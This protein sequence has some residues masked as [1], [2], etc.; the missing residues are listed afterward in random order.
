MQCCF[1]VCVCFNR[2]ILFVPSCGQNEQE[3]KCVVQY[4]HVFDELL[5]QFRGGDVYDVCESVLSETPEL[6][7]QNIKPVDPCI[8]VAQS[9]RDRNENR[10]AFANSET[11]VFLPF[12]T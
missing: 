4:L 11:V 3:G 5:Q 7:L 12:P 10:P 8:T 1:G 2:F 9:E 6:N